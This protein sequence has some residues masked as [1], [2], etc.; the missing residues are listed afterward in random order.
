LQKLK[1]YNKL[2]NKLLFDFVDLSSGEEQ[3]EKVLENVK[4]NISF[5]G[6]NL[7]ILACAIVIA[8]VGLNVNSTA[9]IIGAM[10]ISPLMGPIVGAGFALAIYDFELLKKSGKNLI[11]ATI[12]SLIVAVIYFYFSPFKDVTSELR[13]RTSPT[14]YDVLIAFFG[15]LVGVIAITRVEKG[16][17]IPGVAIATALMPPL[18]SAGYGL[19]I[20]NFSYFLG[21]FYLYTIN[22]FF[23]CIA[24]FLILKYLKY[25]PV[26]PLN[27]KFEKQI[28]YGIT[29]L[30]F[31]MIIPSFYLAYKLLQENRYNHKLEQFINN[32]LI[33]KGY[34]IIYKRT[35]F[36]TNPKKIE[37]AF[38]SKKFN[39]NEKKLLNQKLLEYGISNTII[40]I[41]QDNK[42][43]KGEILNEI[44]IRNKALSEKDIVISNLQKELDE[45]KIYNAEIL[46]ELAILFPELKNVSL[47]KHQI[48]ANSDSSKVITVL[49]YHSDEKINTDTT[50]IEKW[51]SQKLK[52]QDIEL[53]QYS[54]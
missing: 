26:K 21:A 16:N 42:D 46:I 39:D 47:G 35:L 13:A 51:L 50:K 14:I 8:S 12:V 43:L 24:T 22:C 54:K 10:L 30:I 40:E 20:G 41:K 5:R 3:K 32:E 15:G 1:F 49:L 33:S 18:C 2:I 19:A 31:V 53:V 48:N 36:N 52:T 29:F 37:L 25:K 9:V 7:W 44:G 34:A 4:S 17:P 11:I 27:Q 23:I 45:F 38:L 28:R 6:S